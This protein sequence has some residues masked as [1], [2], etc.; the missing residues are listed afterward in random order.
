MAPFPPPFQR[1]LRF[2]LRR[3]VASDCD[4]LCDFSKKKKRPIAVWLATGTF[5]TGNRGDLRLRFLVLSG[6]NADGYMTSFMNFWVHHNSLQGSIPHVVGSMTALFRFKVCENSLSGPIPHA[7]GSMIALRFVNVSMNSLRGP[8]PHGVGS[9]TAMGV[10]FSSGNSLSGPIP[11]A[12]GSMAR[13][14][15]FFVP[16]NSLQGPIPHAVGSMTAL[17][18]FDVSE[19]SL[20]GPIPHAFGSMLSL[21]LFAVARNSLSGSIPAVVTCSVTV[22]SA[23]GNQLSGCIPSGLFIP[24]DIGPHAARVFIHGNRLTGSL[25]VFKDLGMLAA[26]GNFL[27]GRIPN[28]FN[29]KLSLLDLSGVPGHSMGLNGPLPPALRQVSELQS[30]TMANQQMDGAVP[31]FSSTLSLL[32]LHKNRFKVLSGFDIGSQESQTR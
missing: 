23:E 12:V 7:V 10:F 15:F 11:H 24:S 27:E 18:Q 17:F 32:A 16:W 1:A 30:L 26:S 14:N 31:S 8:I 13:L 6:A 3:Q 22:I 19:N 29:S 2:L 28:T 21:D 9:I 25:P 20:R 5:A 4:S